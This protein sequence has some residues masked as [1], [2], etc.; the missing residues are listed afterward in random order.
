[1][2]ELSLPENPVYL[3]IITA[4][5]Q[6]GY[7]I[8]IED[9]GIIVGAVDRW[10]GNQVSNHAQ[11][12]SADVERLSKKFSHV[13]IGEKTLKFALLGGKLGLISAK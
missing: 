10:C 13:R 3:N 12:T 11:I 8:S 9:Q 2:N 6:Q 1:M 4:F 7:T 5:E